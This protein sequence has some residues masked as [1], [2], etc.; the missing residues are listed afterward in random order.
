MTVEERQRKFM[1]ASTKH[2]ACQDDGLAKK[3]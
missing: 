2:D 1:P 3:Q